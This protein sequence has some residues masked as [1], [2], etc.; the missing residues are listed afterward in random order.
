MKNFVV[1]M[2]GFWPEDSPIAWGAAAIAKSDGAEVDIEI[3][4]SVT[5]RSIQQPEFMQLVRELAITPTPRISVPRSDALIVFSVRRSFASS[6]LFLNEEPAVARRATQAAWH[7]V[8]EYPE[9]FERFSRR[10]VDDIVR[11]IIRDIKHE[12]AET[13][14]RLSVVL[15]P[16]YP[17]AHALRTLIAPEEQ[18]RRVRRTARAS[19][20][21][22]EW[23]EYETLCRVLAGDSH[24]YELKY[25]GGIAKGGG[26]DLDQTVVQLSALERLHERFREDLVNDCTIFD[27]IADVPAPRLHE[28]RAASAGLHFEVNVEGED[29]LTRL[30]RFLELK[31]LQQVV[32]GEIPE[33]MSSDPAFME[34]VQTLLHPSDDTQV[35]ERRPD[36]T[37]YRKVEFSTFEPEELLPTNS[38]NCFC[39]LQG[40][41]SEARRVELKVAPK[42]RYEVSTRNNGFDEPPSGIEALASGREF[43][44]EPTVA[45]L[46]RFATPSGS[47]ER[48]YAAGFEVLATAGRAEFSWIPSF[49]APG[50]FVRVGVHVVE[51]DGEGILSFD[52]I[53]LLA[54]LLTPG[55]D[56]IA[57][58]LRSFADWCTNI[59]LESS[60]HTDDWIVPARRREPTAF[61]RI[62][63][64]MS[65]TGPRSSVD[66]IVIRLQAKFGS[67]VRRNNTRRTA[68]SN[69]RFFQ[70]VDSDDDG[71]FIELLPAGKKAVN[72]YASYLAAVQKTQ[73]GLSQ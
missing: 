31:L 61:A 33:D 44:F 50:A 64:V 28:L 35:E 66:D 10:V 17:L 1:G 30:A 54:G 52:G 32:S 12:E 46:T 65:D 60:P 70:L 73:E 2:E 62:L 13:L 53:P 56:R 8:Y 23:E 67:R 9:Q 22:S 14:L 48:I 6:S 26:M 39:F 38:F 34:A 11:D 3:E 25:S 20:P 40:I 29:L 15:R 41:I 16:T 21:P 57:A 19:I 68:A 58:W 49:L 37:E 71:S 47:R 4:N 63:D 36:A 43:L 51:R 55:L 24:R 45:S 7:R 5:G 69:S 18:K 27:S 42:T 72:V 59:E